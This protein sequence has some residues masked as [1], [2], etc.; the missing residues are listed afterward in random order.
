MGI[1]RI[2]INQFEKSKPFE[3]SAF[4]YLFSGKCRKPGMYVD[5]YIINNK[6]SLILPMT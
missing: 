2:N 1:E 5:N 6:E 3:V 4:F